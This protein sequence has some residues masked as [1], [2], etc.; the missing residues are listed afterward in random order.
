[1]KLSVALRQS[2]SKDPLAPILWEPHLVALDRR[3][4]IILKGVR[5]CLLKG[6]EVPASDG[7]GDD[8]ED[9]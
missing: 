4:E 8:E 5:D 7:D 6:E 9:T 2:M 3:L 1:M